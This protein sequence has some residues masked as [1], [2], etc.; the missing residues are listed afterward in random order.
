MWETGIEFLAAD[1]SPAQGLFNKQMSVNSPLLRLSSKYFLTKNF[2]NGIKVQ[3]KLN[4]CI[5]MDIQY[6]ISYTYV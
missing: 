5:K 2:N 6:I 4:T 3:A 1:I